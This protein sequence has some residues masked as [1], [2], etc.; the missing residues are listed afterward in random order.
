MAKLDGANRQPVH[1]RAQQRP[2]D[3]V[4]HPAESE[5]GQG[6]AQLRRAQ[7]PVEMFQDMPDGPGPAIALGL[8]FIQLG[9][10][11]LD[12]RKL[13]RDKK[14]VEQDKHEDG[15]D[16]QR[17]STGINCHGCVCMPL[18]ITFKM[19][20]KVTVP[21]SLPSRPRTIASLCR[22][23]CIWPTATSRRVLSSRYNAGWR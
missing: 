16:L 12:Q 14:T 6:D 10:A 3:R 20:C 7:I 2:E 22:G 23:R 1:G 21:T 9:L 11:D 13:G 4:P 5:T 18:K 17:D 8:Q 15:D 19:S